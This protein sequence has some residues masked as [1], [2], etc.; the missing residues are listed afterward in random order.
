MTTGN[1]DTGNG[2][3]AQQQDG[4]IKLLRPGQFARGK[5]I[6]AALVFLNALKKLQFVADDAQAD[7]SGNYHAEGDVKISDTNVILSL[8]LPPI[9]A[10][11]SGGGSG[12]LMAM[13][14][15]SYSTANNYL[16]AQAGSF[17]ADEVFSPAGANINVALPWELRPGQ[18]PGTGFS[19]FPAY[20]AGDII[21]AVVN[22]TGGTG[23]YLGGAFLAYLDLGIGRTWRGAA[24]TYRSTYVSSATYAQ[25]DIVRVQSGTSQGVWVCVIANPGA[26]HQPTYPEPA[27]TGGTN[28]WEMWTFGIYCT[29][30]CDDGSKTVDINATAPY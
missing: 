10:G 25:G 12:G 13:Q 6:N 24:S 19:L 3:S 17:T 5:N 1:P 22:P 18:N 26:G 2:G 20:T 28:Y 9:G 11:G 7:D 8:K 21:F 16:V 14:V 15:I 4:T 23:V 29:S 27:T 30:V